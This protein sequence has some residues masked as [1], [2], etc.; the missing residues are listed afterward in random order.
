M[1][2]NDDEYDDEVVGSSDPLATRQEPDEDYT[3]DYDEYE[4]PPKKDYSNDP[5]VDGRELDLEDG[6]GEGP[7][8]DTTAAESNAEDEGGKEDDEED[9]DDDEVK[10]HSGFVGGKKM[11]DE[12]QQK[13]DDRKKKGCCLLCCCVLLLLMLVVLALLFGVERIGLNGA[14]QQ[15]EEAT[16][17]PTVFV[18]STFNPTTSP[19]VP[20]N[21]PTESPTVFGGTFV[22][23][24]SPTNPPTL[25]P[26]VIP[27][28]VP[29]RLPCD[30]IRVQENVTAGT[31]GENNFKPYP[32]GEAGVQVC[33][34]TFGGQD[35]ERPNRNHWSVRV[36]RKD[37][38]TLD[39]FRGAELCDF[40]GARRCSL[41]E[42]LEGVAAGT[43][44][45]GDQNLLYT[46]SSCQDNEGEAGVYMFNVGLNTTK[47]PF[48]K[49][50]SDLSVQ[51]VIRCCGDNP[52]S[53]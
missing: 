15:R 25:D 42:F 43:G 41:D 10:T 19:V 18:P 14:V 13:K 17:A 30:D 31:F 23:T 26:G 2:G 29:S 44:C 5:D 52:S 50:E 4:P 37:C 47:Q 40:V 27:P 46:G 33:G 34:D 38:P 28:L 45:G 16:E 7:S 51:S 21:E 53:M 8:D 1:S 36:G 6:Q 32:F 11:K 22:P 20:T 9:D 49:C 39:F 24:E 12:E 3:A 48:I 35:P